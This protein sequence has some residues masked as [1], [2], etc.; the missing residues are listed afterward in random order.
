MTQNHA[1]K[2]NENKAGTVQKAAPEVLSK[3][4]WI[5]PPPAKDRDLPG[6]RGIAH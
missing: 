2:I 1:D 4:V 3:T 5:N 6:E